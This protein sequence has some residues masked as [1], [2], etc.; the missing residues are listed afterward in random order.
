MGSYVFQCYVYLDTDVQKTEKDKSMCSC[1]F[2]Q[3]MFRHLDRDYWNIRRTLQN[4][5]KGKEEVNLTLLHL[6]LERRNLS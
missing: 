4:T 3:Y 5:K 2:R 1:Y 6:Y